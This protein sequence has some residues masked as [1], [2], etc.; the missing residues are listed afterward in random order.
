MVNMLIKNQV[1]L[2]QKELIREA[3]KVVSN[4]VQLKKTQ[5]S[6]ASMNFKKS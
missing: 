4:S 6:R 3:I 5:S 1:L 2:Q